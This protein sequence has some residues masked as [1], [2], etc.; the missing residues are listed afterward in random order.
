ME[1][2]NENFLFLKVVQTFI[3]MHINLIESSPQ[4]TA[5]YHSN[6]LQRIETVQTIIEKG[7]G[8]DFPKLFI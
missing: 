6:A 4:Q 7:A 3:L 2:H 8:I 1:N 5:A